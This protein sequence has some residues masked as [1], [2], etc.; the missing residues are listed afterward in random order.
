MGTGGGSGLP[1]NYVI[2]QERDDTTISG[3]ISQIAADLYLTIV[4]MWDRMHDFPFVTDSAQ[5]S[6]FA[7]KKRFLLR[8]TSAETSAA[9]SA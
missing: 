4:Y 3:Y 5:E 9:T 8:S 1:E 6:R 7:I 2:W